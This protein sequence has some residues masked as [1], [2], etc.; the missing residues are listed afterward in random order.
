MNPEQPSTNDHKTE[1][2]STFVNTAINALNK[3]SGTEN[4]PPQ[5]ELQ[6]RI[7]QCIDQDDAEL[8]FFWEELKMLVEK[9]ELNGNLTPRE[10]MNDFIMRL[11][12]DTD[13]DDTIGHLDSFSKAFSKAIINYIDPN[14]KEIINIFSEYTDN[15]NKLEW[16]V[17]QQGLTS[18]QERI[19]AFEICKR[20]GFTAYLSLI[21]INDFD[22]AEKMVNK[23][24]ELHHG[25]KARGFVKELEEYL[26][27]LKNQ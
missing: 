13:G 15:G 23:Y 1:L 3:A 10:K 12:H 5:E 2:P 18:D 27:E 19:Q 8:E 7:E 22:L 14:N 4:V 17:L 25:M 24:K 20:E 6:Y 26:D 21:G 11:F 16:N 9:G